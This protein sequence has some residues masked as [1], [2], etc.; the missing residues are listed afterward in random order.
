MK[1]VK[2]S[3]YE[4]LQAVLVKLC[5][6]VRGFKRF[7]IRLDRRQE[8]IRTRGLEI[9]TFSRC[10]SSSYLFKSYLHSTPMSTHKKRK[11]TA[12]RVERNYDERYEGSKDLAAL[13]IQAYE[14][15]VVKGSQ[16]EGFAR[17]L[18]FNDMAATPGLIQWMPETSHGSQENGKAIWVDRYA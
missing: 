12:S 3:V 16:A 4:V 18:E 6:R 17:S 13:Y 8:I 5:R 9:W 1:E 10:S 11:Y 2:I 14:A 15:D 7:E